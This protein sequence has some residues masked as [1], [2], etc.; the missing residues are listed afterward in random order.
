[1]STMEKQL[2]EMLQ[3]GE[4]EIKDEEDDDYLSLDEEEKDQLRR[5][6]SLIFKRS[7]CCFFAEIVVF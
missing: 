1:M 2:E 4:Q 3:Q 7:F 6:S 5:F